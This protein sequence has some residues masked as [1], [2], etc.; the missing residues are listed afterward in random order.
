LFDVS[1]ILARQGLPFRG[2]RE[3]KNGNFNHIVSLLSRHCPVM[4][5]WIEQ[6]KFRPYR[7]NY[8]S[9]DS[10]Y[11][12][13]TLLALETKKQIVNEVNVANMYSVMSNTTPDLSNRGQMSFCVLYVDSSGKVIERLLE[14]LEVTDKTGKSTAQNICD[15]ST[16]NCL[17]LEL[18]EF[19]SYDYASS[20]S[21]KFQRAQAM[22]SELFGYH[23]PYIPCQAYRLNAFV[24]HSCETS[25]IVCELFSTLESLYV[26]FSS[27]TKK[28]FTLDKTL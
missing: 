26:F 5:T 23:I 8:M 14:L 22:L 11:E 10:K 24:E 3:E 15:V 4:K 28:S 9:H 2:D 13:I 19:Q 12:F 6:S 25:I 20:M 17:D 7:V 1:R 21:G 18:I 27:S 16:K